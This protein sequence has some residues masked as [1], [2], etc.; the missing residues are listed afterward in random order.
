MH[1]SQKTLVG[2][3][4]RACMYVHVCTAWC[5]GYVVLLLPRTSHFVLV[6]AGPAPPSVRCKHV[7]RRGQKAGNGQEQGKQAHAILD[8]ICARRAACRWGRHDVGQARRGDGNLGLLP[9]GVWSIRSTLKHCK[10][11]FSVLTRYAL[12]DGSSVVYGIRYFSPGGLSFG[13]AV[14]GSWGHKRRM[15]ACRVPVDRT[16]ISRHSRQWAV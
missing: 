12:P 9:R 14:H 13:E 5:T 4:S 16:R 6:R 2:V 7:P 10:C 3:G 15:Y 11:A 1:L 8:Q